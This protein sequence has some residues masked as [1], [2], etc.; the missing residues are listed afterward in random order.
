MVPELIKD[1]T[2]HRYLGA[3][4]LNDK[5]SISVQEF[6]LLPFLFFGNFKERDDSYVCAHE[7]YYHAIKISKNTKIA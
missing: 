7:S 2:S 6:I 4:Y 5:Y 3:A 1:I